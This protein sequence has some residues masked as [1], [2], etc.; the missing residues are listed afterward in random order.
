MLR[1]KEAVD[2]VFLVLVLFEVRHTL[3]ELL[4]CEAG[5]DGKVVEFVEPCQTRVLTKQLV[6]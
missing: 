4:D 6:E 5:G 3:D 2:E 1:S